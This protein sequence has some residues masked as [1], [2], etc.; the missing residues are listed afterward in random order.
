LSKPTPSNPSWDVL[1]EHQGGETLANDS[2]G[3]RDWPGAVFTP[4]SRIGI[5]FPFT[6][7]AVRL[8]WEPSAENIHH[9]KKGSRVESSKV[10]APNRM[11]LHGLIF[12][13]RQLNGRGVGFP[14]NT[15]RNSGVMEDK[16]DSGFEHSDSAAKAEDNWLGINHTLPPVHSKS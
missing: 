16:L 14:L 6:G 8:A 15:T 5:P 1:E 2:D 10:A 9:S 4:A 12:H 13:P 11:R 7:E 3:L